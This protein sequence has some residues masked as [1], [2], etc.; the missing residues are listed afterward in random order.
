MYDP[1]AVRLGP[2]ISLFPC[3]QYEGLGTRDLLIS[4]SHDPS[5]YS[6]SMGV[7]QGRIQDFGQIGRGGG[8]FSMHIL[9]A[10]EEKN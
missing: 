8:N 2:R 4:N 5:M 7:V 9:S 1:L 10:E 3:L 6:L